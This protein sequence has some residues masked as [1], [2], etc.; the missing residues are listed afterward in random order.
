[1]N[2]TD[3]AII[4]L[5]SLATAQ[6]AAQGF[7]R[8]LAGPI[9]FALSVIA[10]YCTLL[11]THNF[12]IVALAALL[13]S[14]LIV[15][16]INSL[17]SLLSFGQ[18][19]QSSAPDQ[20]TGALV[21]LAWWGAT[22]SFVLLL[23]TS[24]K[25]PDDRLEALRQNLA[26]S[27]TCHLLE[28]HLLGM[29]ATHSPAPDCASHACALSPSDAEALNNDPDVQSLLANPRVNKALTDRTL[30]EAIEKRDVQQIMSNPTLTEL[31]QD[32]GLLVTLLKIY[33]K[34]RAKI[35]LPSG[36]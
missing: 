18:P 15:G 17:L 27:A 19:Q 32:T 12:F 4:I 9:S 6:G 31:A 1:M 36:I 20:I 22:I 34:L 3:V 29:K 23:V 28:R 7:W 11:A 13:T 10:A 8:S 24:A 25:L 21:N 26:S 5:L 14:I 30:R 33:P 2:Q 35:S 16:M